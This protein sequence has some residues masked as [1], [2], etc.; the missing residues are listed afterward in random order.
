MFFQKAQMTEDVSQQRELEKNLLLLCQK[1][2]PGI[3]KMKKPVENQLAKDY[4]PSEKQNHRIRIKYFVW[5]PS[6]Y[7]VRDQ[8]QFSL[9]LFNENVLT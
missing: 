1:Y 3:S 4:I 7:Y 2:T 8:R 5:G 9:T 6:L